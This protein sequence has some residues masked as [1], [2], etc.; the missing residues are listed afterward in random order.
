[1]SSQMMRSFESRAALLAG[2]RSE[3][4]MREFVSFEQTVSLERFAALL[5]D[6][7]SLFVVDIEHMVLEDAD[8]GKSLAAILANDITFLHVEL[9]VPSEVVLVGALERATVNIT[10]ELLLTLVNTSH[11]LHARL[12]RCQVLRANRAAENCLQWRLLVGFAQMN[13]RLQMA[14]VTALFYEHLSTVL[15][16]IRTS[17]KKRHNLMKCEQH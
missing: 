4:L 7:V 1:M 6:K 10:D 17:W 5:A 8:A 12:S 2:K 14:Q 3:L 9:L 11:V 13:S 16:K 15:T